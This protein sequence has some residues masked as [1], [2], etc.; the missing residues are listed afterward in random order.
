MAGIGHI[1]LNVSDFLQS[2]AFYDRVLSGLGFTTN[3]REENADVAVKSYVSGEHNIWIR[4]DRTALHQPFVRDIG[5][6][7]LALSAR[8]KDEVDRIYEELRAVNATVTRPPASYPEYSPDYYAF[9]FRDPD[10]IPLEIAY[11]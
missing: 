7:H 2:E 11:S 4:S 1:M 9:Y 8:S 6:D 10:G 5:L 3:H